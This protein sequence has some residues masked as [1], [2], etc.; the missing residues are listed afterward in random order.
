VRRS[1]RNARVLARIAAGLLVLRWL[2]QYW[3]IA[4]AFQG[5]E[6]APH[7]LDLV[8]PV[9]LGALV[10]GLCVSNLHGRPLVSLQDAKLLGQ[11]EVHA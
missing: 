9:T 8:A 3:L 11:L 7:W 1:K 2:D 5:A 4:P 10:L 6:L